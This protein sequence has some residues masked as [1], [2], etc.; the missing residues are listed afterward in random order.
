MTTAD[1]WADSF[2]RQAA[3]DFHAWEL[4][5]AYPAA[6]AA[7]CHKLQFLQM[8]CEKLC[9][10]H[11]IRAGA[12]PESQIGTHRVVAKNLPTI[13]R[14]EMI[15]RNA[16]AKAIAHLSRHV[17][18]LAL[19]I[20]L[21]TPALSLD[22]QRPDNCEYPWQVDHEILSPLTWDFSLLHLCTEPTGRTFLKLLRC[23]I[24][25]NLPK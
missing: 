16:R 11:R 20:E 14:E 25:S 15:R 12:S 8:A 21:L 5:E 18:H 9:K 13:I 24:D 7:A 10:A 3:A 17:R 2:A 1:V 19:E 23:A 4:Y 6:L 22:G